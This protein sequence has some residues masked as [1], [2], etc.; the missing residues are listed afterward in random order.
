MFKTYRKNKLNQRLAGLEVKAKALKLDIHD[1]YYMDQ[2]LNA[3]KEIAETKEAL[4][5][6]G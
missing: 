4:L 6:L 5:Q 3:I 2:Y 1:R